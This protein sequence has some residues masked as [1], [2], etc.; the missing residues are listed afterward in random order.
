MQVYL[1][2][3]VMV[4]DAVDGQADHLDVALRELRTQCGCPSELGGADRRVV[5]RVREQDT[6]A[7]RA[8]ISQSLADTMQNRWLSLAGPEVDFGELHAGLEVLE[9]FRS[10]TF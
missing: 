7:V 2:P 8:K 4:L 9:R 5:Q 3:A 10:M 6:P 1:A